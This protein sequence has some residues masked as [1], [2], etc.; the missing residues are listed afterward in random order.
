[1]L[2]ERLLK[3]KELVVQPGDE[4]REVRQQEKCK[5]SVDLC[6]RSR[7]WSHTHTFHPQVILS[8]YP[9]TMKDNLDLHKFARPTTIVQTMASTVIL[10]SA[11]V[12][13]VFAN[14]DVLNSSEN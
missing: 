13:M 12:F 14:A 1:M 7:K 6:G 9:N 8:K 3:L 10:Q 4:P 11:F 2:L 5:L